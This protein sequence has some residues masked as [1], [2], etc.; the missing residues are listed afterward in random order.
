MRTDDFDRGLARRQ[1]V[2]GHDWVERATQGA[3]AFTAPWQDFI[4]RTAW[5]EVW[6]RDGLATPVRRPLAMMATLALGHGAEFEMHVRAAV[7]AGMPPGEVQDLL[8]LAAVYCGVPAANAG[9]RTAAAVLAEEGLESAPAPLR[10]ERRERRFR[11]FS[12]P[13]LQLVLQGPE[14]GTPVLLCHALGLDGSM[15]SDVAAH[16]AERGH[17]VL[18]HDLRGHGGSALGAE[19]GIDALV[20]DA[21]RL[22]REWGQGPVMCVGLSLGG[23]VA[24]GLAIRHPASVRGLVL[25]NTVAAYPPSAREGFVTRAAQ[26]RAGGMMAVIDTL[27]A[28]YDRLGQSHLTGHRRR[29]V[30]GARD[31]PGGH[32]DC[33]R[34]SRGTWAGGRKAIPCGG[35]PRTGLR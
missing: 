22:V 24:Q 28:R 33:A 16:L 31:H 4:T 27:M 26:V 5:A 30:V 19:A 18:R 2:L 6:G 1:A 21:A 20:D 15:W 10:P 17:P 14:F 13:Q 25:S 29:L 11:T 7:R 32:P 9:F 8:M 34:L 35:P 23:M 12:Q 3:T